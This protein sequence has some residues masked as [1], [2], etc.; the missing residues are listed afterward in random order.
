MESI[1]YIGCYKQYKILSKDPHIT[2]VLA[3][4]KFKDAS[5]CAKGF[6]LKGGL[7]RQPCTDPK[8][9]LEKYQVMEAADLL[10][11]WLFPK[12]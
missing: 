3:P 9:L 5:S 12:K 6:R 11:I 8:C 10:V 4:A 7:K 1:L 2:L